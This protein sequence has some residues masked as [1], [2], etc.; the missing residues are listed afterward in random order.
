MKTNEA[1]A[2][3]IEAA[4][5]TA[6]DEL[7]A[8]TIEEYNATMEKEAKKRL[9]DALFRLYHNDRETFVKRLQFNEKNAVEAFTT[10]YVGK[11]ENGEKVTL[12]AKVKFTIFSLLT[13]ENDAKRV[14]RNAIRDNVEAIAKE[15][16]ATPTKQAKSKAVDNIREAYRLLGF[17]EYAEKVNAT[18]AKRILCNAYRMT[19]N[20]KDDARKN[21]VK[22]SLQAVLWRMVNGKEATNAMTE[23]ENKKNADEAA[24]TK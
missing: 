23:R 19:D 5:A 8:L 10:E 4:E 21:E 18:D 24:A 11:D 20:G 7:F 22:R 13:D 12:T 3:K 9:T 1:T 6:T 15:A 17:T 2:T 14:R 16:S